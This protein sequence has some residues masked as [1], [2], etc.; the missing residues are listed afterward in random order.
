[1]NLALIDFKEKHPEKSKDL[2]NDIHL[3]CPKGNILT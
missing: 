3:F 1:M 2:R